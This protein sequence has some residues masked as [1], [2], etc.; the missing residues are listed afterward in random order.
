M[1]LLLCIVILGLYFLQWMKWHTT[2]HLENK[3]NSDIPTCT[4]VIPFRNEEKNLPILLTSLQKNLPAQW[5]II[6]VDDHSVDA[7]CQHIQAFLN[8]NTQLI[9]AKGQGKKRA[10]RTGIE[11]AHTEWIITMDADL[12]LSVG[13]ESNLYLADWSSD[14]IIFSLEMEGGNSLIENAQKLEFSIF[15]YLTRQSCYRG[16]PQ[17]SNGAYFGFRRMSFIQVGGYELHQEISSGDDQFLLA[18]FRQNQKSIS[19]HDTAGKARVSGLLDIKS[20]IQQ[21]LRWAEKSKDMPLQDMRYLG[22]ITLLANIVALTLPWQTTPIVCFG[23]LLLKWLPEYYAISPSLRKRLPLFTIFF[24]I[25]YPI[26]VLTVGIGL[27]IFP[28]EWKGRQLNQS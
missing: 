26:W 6:L 4:I 5:R 22:I 14:M 12:Q 28:I 3:V 27:L 18:Y 16:Q 15:Q 1:L 13:W 2:S 20:V 8:L 10:L 24:L 25:T 9:K 21:R 17:L 7:T 11:L 23:L 19:Y